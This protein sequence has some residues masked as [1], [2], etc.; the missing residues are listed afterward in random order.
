MLA[1]NPK[2]HPLHAGT[3]PTR[4]L[5]LVGGC[6]GCGQGAMDAYFLGAHGGAPPVSHAGTATTSIFL[7]DRSAPPS[8]LF[9]VAR[10][11]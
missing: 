2:T 9:P 11:H 1:R 7:P 10:R 4:G 6:V 3:L 5:L 8:A